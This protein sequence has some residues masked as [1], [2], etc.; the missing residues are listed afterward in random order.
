MRNCHVVHNIGIA[1]YDLF[2]IIID[3]TL[4][5]WHVILVCH[6]ATGQQRLV[7]DRKVL[8]IDMIR[9]TADFG[10]AV[11]QGYQTIARLDVIKQS[12]AARKWPDS[13]QRLQINRCCNISTCAEA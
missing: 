8:A 9:Q 6:A 10:R 13:Y 4:Q 1:E 5:L 12:P 3:C 7:V 11:L 2:H